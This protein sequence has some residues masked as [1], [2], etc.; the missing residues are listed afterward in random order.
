[1]EQTS[2]EVEGIEFVEVLEE[3][4]KSAT[5]GGYYGYITGP[6]NET[7]QFQS[8]WYEMQDY[9]ERVI[10]ED[11]FPMLYTYNGKNGRVED[12]RGRINAHKEYIRTLL[13]QG[14]L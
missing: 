6:N 11:S 8:G 7:I 10:I 5:N 2:F 1:M 14:E 12:V 4:N 9:E 13:K 3:E